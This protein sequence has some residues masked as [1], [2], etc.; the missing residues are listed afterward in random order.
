MRQ[1]FNKYIRHVGVVRILV[2]L[3]FLLIQIYSIA[4][5]TW[6]DGK[7]KFT[8][9]SE[10]D[11]TVSVTK[12]TDAISG[13][14]VIP[15]TVT[16]NGKS[17][18][19]TTIA[20]QAFYYCVG[21]TS[22]TIPNG[23]VSIGDYAF[24][25]CGELASIT[26]PNSVTSI[27]CNAFVGCSGLTSVT[28]GNSVTSIG[29]YAF[30]HCSKLTGIVIP[31]SVIT[32]GHSAFFYCTG[33]T[34]VNIGNGVTSI[35]DRAFFYCP[36]LKSVKIPAS[37]TSIGECAFNDIR[38]K[39]VV[40]NAKTPAQLSPEAFA[41]DKKVST[42]YVPEGC[43]CAYADAEYWKEF[44][45]IIVYRKGDENG[46]VI[47][48]LYYNAYSETKAFVM[49]DTPSITGD[50]TIASEVNINGKKYTVDVISDYAF[51]ECSAI[52]SVTVGDSVVSIG[53]SA[54]YNC[55][56]IESL[57]IGNSV[58]SI[59]DSAFA[60]CYF[61]N[62]LK[63][64]D[65]VASI[66]EDA[67]YGC[68]GLQSVKIPSS[69]IFFGEN[70]FY[71]HRL[72]TV[73]VE[74]NTPAK[75]SA[76]VFKIGKTATLYVPKGCEHAYSEAEYWKEFPNIM[77]CRKGVENV[78]VIGDLCYKPY[79]KTSAFVEAHTPKIAGDVTIASEINVNGRKYTVDA[80]AGFAF[81]EC[82]GITSVTIPNSITSIGEYAFDRCYGLT[83]L[84]IPNSVTSIG[85]YTFIYCET[86]NSVNIPNSV[87]SLG[88][89]AF[90]GCFGLSS[91]I[92]PNS[93][94]SI[95]NDTF[96]A[97]RSLTS[98]TIPDSVTSIGD[99]AFAYCESLTA[100]I[101]PSS[102]ASIG[103]DVFYN[104]ENIKAIYSLLPTPLKVE[105]ET[106]NY[107]DKKNCK[108]YVPVKSL[109]I[110]KTA[111]GWKDFV[112]IIG[113]KFQNNSSQIEVQK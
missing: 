48:E 29:A 49:T 53:N 86:F 99:N 13:E 40:V 90:Y 73:I 77:A 68:F 33:L 34:S 59:G 35:G 72:N 100:I 36:N 22:V 44:P 95:K 67:F 54:F 32:I 15:D 57:T 26:I 42:L 91:V 98:V 4:E 5:T 19:V 50:V 88:R 51:Y 66:G 70:A 58:I 43:E 103:N 14:I 30:S 55:L 24:G 6:T 84:T 83:S 85:D 38:L 39:T 27:G 102:V 46:C 108:L 23:V 75:L 93:V 78:C 89:G 96:Y 2:L 110:Y 109:D 37:V 113:W 11:A 107:V 82:L 74:S 64:G 76:Q 17:Y 56:A 65:N 97:C 69:V 104:C 112:N 20:N 60:G 31:N 7:L 21:L 12:S 63:I 62:S 3:A 71:N 10:E 52:S 18:S 111:C 47:D 105:S 61:M 9:V 81:S 101:I 1:T 16:K 28:I 92:I 106:F 87:I 25:G 94:T 8:V 79:S 80:I 45:N 41:I